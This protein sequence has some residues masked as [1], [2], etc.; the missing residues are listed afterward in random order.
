MIQTRSHREKRQRR[1]HSDSDE[2][3]S[4]EARHHDRERK[5]PRLALDEALILVLHFKVFLIPSLQTSNRLPR[6]KTTPKRA[7]L[8]RR[9]RILMNQGLE[10]TPKPANRA[11]SRS[12]LVSIISFPFTDRRETTLQIAVWSEI[13][14]GSGEYAS[15]AWLERSSHQSVPQPR[16][17]SQSVLLPLQRPRRAAGDGKVESEGQSAV[18]EAHCAEWSGLSSW[19]WK[20]K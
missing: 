14:P 13:E 18:F 6:K 1:S 9:R 16:N 4:D 5:G 3:S 19:H 10:T 20:P 8:R 15:P 12:S 2:F 11:K 17:E 7:T